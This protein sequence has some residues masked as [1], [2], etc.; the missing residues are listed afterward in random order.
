MKKSNYKR[1]GNFKK[2][3]QLRK[4]V[5]GFKVPYLNKIPA[6]LPG[7]NAPEKK[8]LDVETFGVAEN[9]STSGTGWC[10]NIVKE[11]SGPSQRIGRKITMKSLRLRGVIVPPGGY[12]QYQILRF[13]VVYDR[14]TNGTLPVFTTLF[15]NIDLN[16][17][18]TSGALASLSVNMTERI[19]VLMDET[20]V[21]ASENNSSTTGL[22]T[23]NT[24]GLTDTQSK[25]I[26]FDRYIKL[27]QETQYKGTTGVIGDISTGGVY[28]YFLFNTGGAT[29]LALMCNSRLRYVD[30]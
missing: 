21:V 12:D 4:K 29:G 1:K 2:T 15:Q 11:G 3:K 27:N 14:Q 17:A 20:M 9:W 28:A 7:T 10:L 19:T 26:N 25:L 23:D 6:S 24:I 30:I 5:G 13:I 16:G 22:A 18:F 8:T